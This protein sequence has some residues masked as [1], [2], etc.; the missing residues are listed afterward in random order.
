M[1]AAPFRWVDSGRDPVRS[2]GG[3]NWRC[4]PCARGGCVGYISRG[5]LAR[6]RWTGLGYVV[7]Q[8]VPLKNG[9]L[10]RLS[11]E[12][13]QPAGVKDPPDARTLRRA[14]QFV[15]DQDADSTD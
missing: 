3:L 12:L 4:T 14:S 11:F 6:E 13:F 10:V 8:E 1:P 7:W 2:A 9:A 15:R 5:R